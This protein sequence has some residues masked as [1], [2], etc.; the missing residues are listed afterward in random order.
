V[1]H[2]GKRKRKSQPR[3]ARTA[4]GSAPTFTVKLAEDGAYCVLMGGNASAP[5]MHIGNFAS[6]DAAHAWIR[7]E[8]AAWFAKR[9]ATRM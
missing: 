8:S 1:K 9:S 5:T 2:R 7:D 3:K 6:E 4:K